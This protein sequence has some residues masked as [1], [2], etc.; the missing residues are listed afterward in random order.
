MALKI[1]LSL[2]NK[3]TENYPCILKHKT[4]VNLN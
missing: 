3:N 1:N 2:P 4:T